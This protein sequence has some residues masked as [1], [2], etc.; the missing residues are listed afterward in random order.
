M[1]RKKIKL[2]FIRNETERK[3]CFKKRKNG[4]IKKVQE[5]ST[6]CG[7]DACAIIYGP[8][9][10]EPETWP[11]SPPAVLDLLE[12]Y[13]SL[14]ERFRRLEN[15]QSYTR[16]R[17]DK[18]HE[19][20]RRKHNGIRENEVTNIMY[21]CLRGEEV[22]NLRW[23]DLNELEWMVSRNLREVSRRISVLKE[24]V[25][26]P[27]APKAPLE[28]GGYGGNDEGMVAP[29]LP[30][31]EMRKFTWP[32]LN[33]SMV[34]PVMPFG[35][36][37]NLTRLLTNARMVA[38]EMPSSEIQNLTWPA[39]TTTSAVGNQMENFKWFSNNGSMVVPEMPLGLMQNPTW[40]TNDAPM[41]AP[42][43]QN[44]TR[45]TNNASIAAP[46]MQNSTWST[47]NSS[48]L[49]PEFSMSEMQRPTWSTNISSMVAP[50]MLVSDMQNWAW[51]TNNASMLTPDMLTNE[52]QN[53][54]WSANKASM[55]APERPMSKMP[56]PAWSANKAHMVAPE[57][58]RDEL[59]IYAVDMDMLNVQPWLSDFV[60][61]DSFFEPINNNGAGPSNRA[62]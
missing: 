1:T 25:P 43:M 62:P 46:E 50:E 7:I 21:R 57:M 8:H 47:C 36:M 26:Q 35:D 30:V 12:R 23:A 17:V 34:A 52:M 54:T 29:E 31:N 55:V 41:V 20:I 59:Q 2:A 6:L 56:N 53:I 48:M 19:Q 22:Q 24:T 39:T 58:D 37:Q 28:T 16:S 32:S 27:S 14:P 44:P 13:K 11:P 45:F 49:A 42:E 9:D 61:N 4:L 3:T 33:A 18:V 10:Q 60:W 40:F 5:L 51:S 38:P 15:Q